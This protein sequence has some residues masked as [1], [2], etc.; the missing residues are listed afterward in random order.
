MVAMMKRY[1][2]RDLENKRKTMLNLVTL[3]DSVD[4]VS[5]LVALP[6][7]NMSDIKVMMAIAQIINK[8]LEQLRCPPASGG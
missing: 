5:A 4:E 7:G 3:A 8:R 2:H 1:Q 6:R